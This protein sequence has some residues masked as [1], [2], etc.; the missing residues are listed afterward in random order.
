MG[1]QQSDWDSDYKALADELQGLAASMRATADGDTAIDAFISSMPGAL[2]RS[3]VAFNTV[4][5]SLPT[6]Q[7]SELQQQQIA[8]AS[9]WL[10][11]LEFY[12][13][14]HLSK[15]CTFLRSQVSSSKQQTSGA[16]DH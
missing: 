2:D 16:K 14:E 3:R 5:V 6:Q 7:E 9:A 1:Y 8:S 11:H 15:P 10:P 13:S 4:A 12:D